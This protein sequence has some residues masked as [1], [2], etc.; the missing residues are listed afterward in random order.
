[1][2][3][4]S[5]IV[6]CFII[7][8]VSCEKNLLKSVN[9]EEMSNQLDSASFSIECTTLSLCQGDTRILSASVGFMKDKEN[10]LIVEPRWKLEGNDGIICDVDEK[11]KR[12]C[13]ICAKGAGRAVLRAEWENKYVSECAISIDTLIDL[14][15]SVKWASHNLGSKYVFDYGG[16]YAWGECEPKSVGNESNYSLSI[17]SKISG[18]Y[19]MIKYNVYDGKLTLESCD[20]AASSSLKN[21]YRTP[22]NIEVN[23]LLDNC[24][25]V[26]VKLSESPLVYGM[27]FTSRKDGFTDKSIYFP[28]SSVQYYGPSWDEGFSYWTSSRSVNDESHSDYLCLENNAASNIASINEPSKPNGDPRYLLKLIRPVK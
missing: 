1:M 11:D 18:R 13:V 19:E 3:N 21:G 9:G 27:K 28:V 17:E 5:A 7:C 15:L 26:W 23:E 22:T 10:R 14:G 16:A 20:D 12:S 8:L 6:L 24:N 25:H 2:R 4:T